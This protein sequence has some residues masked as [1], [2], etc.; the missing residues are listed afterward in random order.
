MLSRLYSTLL[1]M[2]GVAFAGQ[3]FSADAALLPSQFSDCVAAIGVNVPVVQPGQPSRVE[4][5]A[6]ATGFFYGFQVTNDPDPTKRLY[7]TYLITAKHVITELR[8]TNLEGL[9]I[10][11]NPTEGSSQSSEIAIPIRDTAGQNQWFF[12][13]RPRH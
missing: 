10:R 1:V 7:E 9:F 2:V 3:H 12:R 5:D 8:S 13:S 4:F 6:I 11:V